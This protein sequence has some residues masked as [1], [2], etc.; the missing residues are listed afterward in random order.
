MGLL[1]K[2]RKYRNS[3]NTATKAGHFFFHRVTVV[4]D[5]SMA[6][7]HSSENHLISLMARRPAVLKLGEK[8]CVQEKRVQDLRVQNFEH[9]IF[10]HA[11]L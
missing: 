7:G 11:R 1:E 5:F 8:F 3:C 6:M 4:A 10:G 2:T 9:T